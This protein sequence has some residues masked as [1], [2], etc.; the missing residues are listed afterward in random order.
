MSDEHISPPASPKLRVPSVIWVLVGG[1]LA[2]ALIAAAVW[3]ATG[4]GLLRLLTA[5]RE[6]HLVIRADQPT[7]VRQIQQ[8]QRLET[9]RYTMDKIISGEHE[10]PYLPKFLA[11]DRL[12]LIVHGEVIGGVDL[13]K[14]QPSGVTIHAGSVTVRLPQPEILVT[15]LDNSKTRVYSRD[16]GLFSAPDPNLESE[17]RQ[18]AE[19]QLQQA[20]QQD[21]ILPTA[22]QNARDALTA[23][24]KGLGFDQIEFN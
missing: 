23:I 3:L 6:N 1:V 9:V 8:L 7:V 4:I 14:L 18:E 10:N 20:A 15:R 16:T 17:V 11:G 2:V 21:G 5:S 13:T 12:L 19:R 24:L 22:Q